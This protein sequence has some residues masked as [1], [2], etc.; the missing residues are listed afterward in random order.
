[1]SLVRDTLSLTQRWMIHLRK[2]KMS[3]TLGIIQPLI[4]LTLV[5][6]LLDHV[7]TDAS[8]VESLKSLLHDRFAT[9]DYLSFLF[10]GIAVF[11]VLVN[12]IL[13]GIPIVFD[14]ET[15]FMD[16]ILAAPVSRL[17]IVAARFLYVILYSLIQVGIISAV[18]VA[19][20]VRPENPLLALGVLVAY[21]T[22]LCAGITVMSLALAFIFP[23][24]SIFFAITGFLLTPLLVLSPTFVARGSMPGWMQH[25]ATFNPMTHAIEPIRTAFLVPGGGELEPYLVSAGCL[26]IFDVVC[27]ALAVRVIKRRLD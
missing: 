23:H 6:P 3:L 13:G 1:M 22:L 16:K 12:S 25:V 17:S 5:G 11:T 4:L 7:V 27:F 9:T 10:S 15:G 26:L 14:R 21:S 20:G 8:E 24:H 2:D 19:I 18:A